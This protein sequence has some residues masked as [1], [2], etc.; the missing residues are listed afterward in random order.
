MQRQSYWWDGGFEV[1]VYWGLP[2][3]PLP[4]AAL[5]KLNQLLWAGAVPAGDG[6]MRPAADALLVHHAVQVCRPRREPQRDWEAFLGLL[7]EAGDTMP[8]REIA[9][10]TGVTAALN[11]AVAA[12]EAGGGPPGPGSLYGGAWSPAWWLASKL[13]RHA[14]RRLKHLL[15]G[16]PSLG[17]AT[18]RC[19]FGG[20]DV[21]A[22][23]GVFVPTADADI[24]IEMAAE[25]LRTVRNPVV[26]ELGTGCGPIALA[27]GRA[28]PDAEVHAADL[29]ST[30]IRWARKSAR[31]NDLDRVQF[32]TGPL[33]E[34][35][36]TRLHG[37]VDLIAA[38]LPFYPER[39]FASIGSV[40][41]DTIQGEDDDGLG[42]LR[43]L[44]GRAPQ[45]LRPGGMMILQMFSSQW[46][47]LSAELAKRGFRPGTPRVSGPFAICPAELVQN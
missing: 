9:R 25:R 13:Q 45:F 42:L 44:A 39:D 20:V 16:E 27:L 6:L 7:P 4:S 47:V 35:M 37:R 2:A 32:Y 43:Q 36:P 15:A 31:M 3:A 23:P 29:S 8:A 33:V 10:R 14:P 17:E 18:S 30:A 5:S 28:L 24:F 19:R 34:P 1:E 11:R 21:L 40:P 22:G 41:R 12:A 26:V 38:N 46:P